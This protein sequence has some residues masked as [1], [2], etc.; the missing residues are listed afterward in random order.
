MNLKKALELKLQ[1]NKM[2]GVIHIDKEAYICLNDLNNFFPEK[3]IQ[4]WIENKATKD[5]IETVENKLALN[6]ANLKRGIVSR[7]GRLGGTFAHRYI[8]MEFAMWLSPE[9]KLT[10]IQAYEDGISAKQ[11]WNFQRYLAAQGYNILTD[12][13]QKN[14]GN[15]PHDYSNEAILLNKI[16]FGKHETGIRERASTDELDGIAWLQ[17]RN[18]IF[19]EAKIK[20]ETRK[21][22][23]IELWKNKIKNLEIARC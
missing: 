16:I 3:R 13:V 18:G 19:I 8:A 2:V 11:D 23:L 6:G 20:F 9:F 14:I 7:R 10:V 1:Y 15:D 22:L 5:F 12:A 21:E 4:S 17:L